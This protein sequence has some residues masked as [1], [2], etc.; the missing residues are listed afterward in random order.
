MFADCLTAEA[1][2]ELTP[3]YKLMLFPAWTHERISL[4]VVEDLWFFR[5][6]SHSLILTKRVCPLEFAP[7]QLW[8]E[9]VNVARLSS[10]AAL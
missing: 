3:S 9:R 7:F 10:P 6:I 1:I 4:G 8:M 5:F 2:L